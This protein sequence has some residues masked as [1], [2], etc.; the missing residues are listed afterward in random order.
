[1]LQLNTGFRSKARYKVVLNK[2]NNNKTDQKSM[3]IPP[4]T[5]VQFHTQVLKP[6]SSLQRLRI[7]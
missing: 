7:S 4:F 6:T 5:E 2:E 3:L 1:M